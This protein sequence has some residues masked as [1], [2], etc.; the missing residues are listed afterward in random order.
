M[1]KSIFRR[2]YG[3]TALIMLLLLGWAESARAIPEF[4]RKYQMSC[5]ACHAA[6]PR[7]NAFGE[8]F[9]ANNYRLP[10]WRDNTLDTG[11][12]MLALPDHVPLAIRAQTYFQVRNA[13]AIDPL[14]GDRI[15]ANADFQ[16]PYLLKLLS[17]APLSEHLTY[18]FYGIFAEKGENG[19]VVI[20]DAWIRYDDLFCTEIGLQLGQFQ[21]SDLMFPRELRLTFQDFLAYRMAG[22][23]YDR[24]M[25]LD[26]Q[27]GPVSIALGVVNG[28]G[29]DESFTINSPGYRRPD[30]LFDDNSNKSVFGRL[31]ADI[32][33]VSAGLF[34]LT[35]KRRSATGPAGLFDGE[36]D[37]DVNVIGIDLS[38]SI[39]D[40]AHWYFQYLWNSWNDFLQL[41]EF[42]NG[43]SGFGN[44]DW[45]GGFAGVDYIASD[46][47]AFSLLYNYDN[48][49]DLDNTDTIYEG[50]DANT[51]TL[52][53]SYF[54]MRNV[55]G[56]AEINI[57]FLGEQDQRGEYYTGHLDKEPYFLVGFDV[58]F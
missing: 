58:A 47:W 51:L 2:Y 38:G 10:N 19:T 33:P 34:G 25:V 4:A 46:R 45:N 8:Q 6:F 5:A 17:S 14:S 13:G 43:E 53:A 39:G 27:F 16:T 48:A 50:I 18:Y 31:G 24:G 55:K 36:S 32:G 12:N 57:D 26:R 41:E 30:H 21:V 28:N 29:I 35:G 15:N 56:V 1:M 40:K 22:I 20:E 42:D 3:A 49:D 52:T 9:A 37:A 54:F 44:Y 11:D 7:L 23:T